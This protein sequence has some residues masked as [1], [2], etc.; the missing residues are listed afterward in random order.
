MFQ[1]PGLAS[2]IAGYHAF[3]MVGCPIRIFGDQGICAP[4][5]N[6]SQLV[7]SFFA[8]KSLGIHRLPFFCFFYFLKKNCINIFFGVAAFKFKFI[9]LL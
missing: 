1:F 2:R 8:S 3:C 9:Q 6:F 7:T 4:P 5:P